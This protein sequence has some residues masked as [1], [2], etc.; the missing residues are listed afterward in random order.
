MICNILISSK[1]NEL[2]K[3]V[4]TSNKALDKANS[5]DIQLKDEMIE[6]N[7]N[8]KKNMEIL[9]A[10]KTK[11]EKNEKIPQKNEEVQHLI[12]QKKYLKLF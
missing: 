9:E 12:K 5:K 7:K 2:L 11:L 3:Y 1:Y 6:I 10:E 4:E 8:R